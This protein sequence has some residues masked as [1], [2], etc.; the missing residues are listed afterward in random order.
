MFPLTTFISQRWYRKHTR[1]S[2]ELY[3]KLA[4]GSLKQST[5]DDEGWKHGML[6][7]P[8]SLEKNY[9]ST[10]AIHINGTAVRYLTAAQGRERQGSLS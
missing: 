6:R 1:V 2:S 4:Q 9:P 3:R 10:P 7:P 5:D 8:P